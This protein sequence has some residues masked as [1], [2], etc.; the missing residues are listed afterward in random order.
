MRVMSYENSTLNERQMD[1]I[2]N[3]LI[4]AQ[5]DKLTLFVSLDTPPERWRQ[6]VNRRWQMVSWRSDGISSRLASY[7]TNSNCNTALRYSREDEGEAEGGHGARTRR[8]AMNNEQWNFNADERRRC[9]KR[10]WTWVDSVDCRLSIVHQQSGIRTVGSASKNF[11]FHSSSRQKNWVEILCSTPLPDL[12]STPLPTKKVHWIL[13]STSL[14]FKYTHLGQ[15]IISL[16][17]THCLGC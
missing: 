7:F 15:N 16:L 8:R 5:N 12:C 1:V 10:R 14:Q 13:C 4:V 11:M 17:F 6:L 2:K 9:G 3:I